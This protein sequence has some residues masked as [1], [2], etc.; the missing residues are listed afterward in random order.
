MVLIW[1]LP[2]KKG[3]VPGKPAIISKNGED[4][5]KNGEDPRKNGKGRCKIG[6]S[7][8]SCK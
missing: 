4:P 5:R 3:K 8:Q 2:E 7:F 1:G 6:N